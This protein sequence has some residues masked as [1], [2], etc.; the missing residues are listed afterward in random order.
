MTEA[1]DMLALLARDSG[2]HERQNFRD[3]LDH[4]FRAV[5]VHELSS[6]PPGGYLPAKPLRL[7]P[8]SKLRPRFF[9]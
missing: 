9:M 8:I 2:T 3:A 4:L 1:L 7:E 6:A 5:S